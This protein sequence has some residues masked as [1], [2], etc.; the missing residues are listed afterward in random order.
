M[1]NLIKKREILKNPSVISLF[2]LS[3]KL[4]PKSETLSIKSPKYA[5]NKRNK[6]MKNPFPNQVRNRRQEI[7]TRLQK[8]ERNQNKNA[9]QN[10][11]Q[12]KHVFEIFEFYKR[13]FQRDQ[14]KLS[15]SQ[16]KQSLNFKLSFNKNS[17]NLI[18]PPN[19][20]IYTSKRK[21]RNSGTQ[22]RTIA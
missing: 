14:E 8:M 13:R 10:Q 16:A 19:G 1:Q 6:L 17:L 9:K 18:V 11:W 2:R 3:R 12:N 4:V 7:S 20:K 22:P 5:R 15:N 21:T